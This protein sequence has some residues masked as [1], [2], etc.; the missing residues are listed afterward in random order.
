MG[1]R[2][3]LNMLTGKKKNQQNAN[4]SS[5]IERR[6]VQSGK[7]VRGLPKKRLGRAEVTYRVKF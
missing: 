7:G 5:A 2:G 6:R 3:G 4:R 1:G